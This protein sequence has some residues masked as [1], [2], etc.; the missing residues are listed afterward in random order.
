MVPHCKPP[1]WPDSIAS[2]R[3]ASHI[4]TQSSEGCDIAIL[5]LADDLGVR[6]NNGRP[7]AAQ[8]PTHIRQALSVYGVHDPAGVTH[9]KIF[10]A[11]DIVPSPGDG[12]EA[13]H[14][15]HQRVYEAVRCLLNAGLFVLPMGGGHDLTFPC[16][17]AVIDHATSMGQTL[18]WHGIYIDAHLDVRDTPGSGMP[19]RRLLETC[20]IRGLE[21]I[22]M[23]PLV[24]SQV[25]WDWFTAHGGTARNSIGESALGSPDINTFLSFDLDAID[26]AHAPGVSALN[27]AGIDSRT[28]QSIAY[29]CGIAAGRG[30]HHPGGA[31]RYFDLMELCPAH[32]VSNRTAR[33]TAHL[34]LSFSTGF[35]AGKRGASLE[36]SSTFTNDVRVP[37]R[38]NQSGNIKPA[39]ILIR[40]A[41]VLSMCHG[42]SSGQRSRALRGREME[43]C[44]VI[45]NADVLLEGGI[46]TKV[47]AH[48]TDAQGIA[49]SQLTTHANI[50][51]ID[52]AGCVLLPGLIDCHT[53]L[54]WAGSRVEE[55]TQKLA[56]TPY[57][58]LLAKGG[59]I[60]ST[61]RATRLA[62][63]EELTDLLVQRLETIFSRGVTSTIEVKSGYGLSTNDEL[64]ML[65]AIVGAASFLG[66]QSRVVPTALI[67]HAID[68]QDSDFVNRTIQET[69]PAISSEFP[70]I[71]IDAYCE[72]GAWSLEDCKRLFEAAQTLGHPCR[73]HAD[74]FND[75]EMIP[76]STSKSFKSV[77][78]LESSAP[79]HVNLLAQSS[80]IGVGLPLCG[81]HMAD[82]K[83]APLRALIDAG[84]AC[85]VATNSNPGS[86]PSASLP[87]AMAIAVRYCG[88][89]PREALAAA[90]INAATVLGLKDRGRIHPGE[91]A[92]VML[93]HTRDER[94]VAYGLG[95]MPLKLSI[96]GGVI[97]NVDE[98]TI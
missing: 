45:P 54:C 2:T 66:L 30:H 7:G 47:L 87:L 22:G 16:V 67:G 26:A 37:S 72:K 32:D 91:M 75:L 48:A 43:S 85:A 3:F 84:G 21:I 14:A 56:G 88:L 71:T 44:G 33:L 98:A 63:E 65:R 51:V 89:T 12:V 6:L 93:L 90:T 80:T 8:G 40:N 13:L 78:H 11:G 38:W 17:R 55:W 95:E 15:T 29:K 5:G 82:G 62:S 81:L 36:D 92:D 39:P 23:N 50:E 59:G 58:E 35:A 76:W 97:Q 4:H 1:L 60:M 86:A 41:R 42:E 20:P 53:H 49:P 68:S 69:L 24:N 34:I 79:A 74:Q 9:A 52:A 18:P 10:D 27:A 94:E 61:V 73:V 31:L 57:L 28:A 96:R 46:I 77:D 19:F 83:F 25:H 64:K 70:G